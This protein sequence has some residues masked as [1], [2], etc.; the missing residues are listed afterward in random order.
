MSATFEEMALKIPRRY[1]DKILE[2]NVIYRAIQDSQD[3]YMIL[4]FTI[5]REYMEPGLREVD[6]TCGICIGRVLDSYRALQSTFVELAKAEKL[7]DL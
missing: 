4:L 1:R 5:W 7:L 3:K 2:E 6:I